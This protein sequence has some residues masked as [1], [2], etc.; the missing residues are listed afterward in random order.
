MH[1]EVSRRN[2]FITITQ[3]TPQGQAAHVKGVKCVHVT[4]MVKA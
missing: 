2:H 3:G 4:L 1:G